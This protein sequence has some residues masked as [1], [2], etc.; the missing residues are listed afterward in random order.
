MDYDDW[1][2][3]MIVLNYF[4]EGRTCSLKEQIYEKYGIDLYIIECLHDSV[5]DDPKFNNTLKIFP[6]LTT[7]NFRIKFIPKYSGNYE[8]YLTNLMGEKIYLESR[9][10]HQELAHTGLYNISLSPGIYYIA[11]QGDKEYCSGKIIIITE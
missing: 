5:K 2:Y 8:F 1:T 3:M 4:L 11:I 9:Y 10:L 6:N 7:G